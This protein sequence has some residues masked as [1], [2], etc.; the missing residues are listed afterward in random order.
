VLDLRW[1]AGTALV[2]LHVNLQT[3]EHCITCT[4]DKQPRLQLLNAVA[5]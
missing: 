2:T 5:A 4:G 3:G 1:A